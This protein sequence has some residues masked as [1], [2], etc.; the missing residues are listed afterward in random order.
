MELCP[1][2]TCL[3]GLADIQS[4]ECIPEIFLTLVCLPTPNYRS[5]LMTII[6]VGTQATIGLVM[7]FR[8]R[9]SADKT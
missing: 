4:G 6:Q 2:L 3:L 9:D 1:D 5:K 7:Y 8:S